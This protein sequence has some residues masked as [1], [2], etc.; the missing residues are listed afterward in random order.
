M[1]E[2]ISV[3]TFIGHCGS[4]K[5][6]L[7][8]WSKKRKKLKKNTITQKDLGAMWI[9]LHSQNGQTNLYQYMTP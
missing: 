3:S 5:P 6:S 7:M 4:S 9:S 1:F 8:A 2:Y